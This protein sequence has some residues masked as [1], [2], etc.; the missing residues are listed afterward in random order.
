MLARHFASRLHRFK[1]AIPRCLRGD[2]QWPEPSKLCGIHRRPLVSLCWLLCFLSTYCWLACVPPFISS[3]SSIQLILYLLHRCIICSQVV[4]LLLLSREHGLRYSVPQ[5]F[6]NICCYCI[7][8][9]CLLSRFSHRIVRLLNFSDAENSKAV[10]SQKTGSC[11]S[12]RLKSSFQFSCRSIFW[13]QVLIKIFIW[14]VWLL[15]SL[16]PRHSWACIHWWFLLVDWKTSGSHSFIYD[17]QM[18]ND[19]RHR[20]LVA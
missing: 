8:L 9:P 3:S 15:C 10:L 1:P 12:S 6:I 13:N 7:W 2:A 4:I 5:H 18:L 11:P 17:W 20:R 19:L 16:T 14:D